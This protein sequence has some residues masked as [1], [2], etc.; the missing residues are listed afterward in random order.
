MKGRLRARLPALASLLALVGFVLLA[1]LR[2]PAFASPRV[3]VDLL[4][5]SAV[6]GLVAL[7][8]TVVIVSGGIDLS[9]GSLLGLCSIAVAVLVE[10]AGW[11]PLAAMCAAVALG[12]AF[13]LAQGALV[14]ALE[15]PA[16][17]V[18]LAGLFLA[19]GLALGLHVEALAIAH[20]FHARL[21]AAE[22]PLGGG[23]GLA[24]GTLLFL[25]AVAALA[26]ALRWTRPGRDLYAVGGDAAAARQ[27]GVATGR[28]QVGAFAASGALT[29]LGAVAYTLYGG[30]GSSTAGLGLELDAIA[31]AV[32]GGALLSGGAGGALGTLCGVLLFGAIQTYLIFE[33][34]LAAG[35][36]RAAAGGLLLAFVA[37]QRWIRAPAQPTI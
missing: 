13:G 33:G 3:L 10:R 1:A 19:R 25:G 32:V 22:L 9:V 12:G 7:G 20:P 2:H 26:C 6:L 29:G 35:W 30:S 8:A 23:L 36:T 27:A 28:A 4:D 17:L 5:D 34:S 11:H 14:R 16:F 18:T 24:P 21:A 31:A 15:L 37:L